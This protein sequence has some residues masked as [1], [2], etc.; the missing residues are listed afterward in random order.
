MFKTIRDA[1]K[2][3]EIRN[4][5][6]FAFFPFAAELAKN[7]R[8]YARLILKSTGV[9]M[10]FCAVIAVAFGLVARPL[11]AF[12]P[13][14]DKYA[15]YWWSVPW[16]IAITGISSLHGFYTTAEIAANRFGFLKWCL[17]LDLLYPDWNQR[18]K[19]HLLPY[20]HLKSP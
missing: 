16:L 3:K 9:N 17:P 20:G 7:R 15:A 14:G 13:H 5:M 8:E 4:A 12:L 18:C 19:S 11:L 6:I 10:A 1:F 2:I